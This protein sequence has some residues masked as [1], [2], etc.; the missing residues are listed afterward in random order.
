[1]KRMVIA[2]KNTIGFAVVIGLCSCANTPDKTLEAAQ[3]SYVK[4]NYGVTFATLQ[5][6][7]NGGDARAQYAL[8]YLYYYGIGRQNDPI[9][10]I[11]WFTLAANQGNPAAI[12]AL[13]IIHRQQPTSIDDNM[14]STNNHAPQMGPPMRTIIKPQSKALPKPQCYVNNTVHAS[15]FVHNAKP[16][17][18][19][20]KK[21]QAGNSSSNN[22][23]SSNNNAPG[24]GNLTLRLYA[25]YEQNKAQAFIHDNNLTS[26]AT[27]NTS[28]INGKTLYTVTYGRYQSMMQAENAMRS[29][30]AAVQATKPWVQKAY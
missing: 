20:N 18:P 8:G 28:T 5:S 23:I 26:A 14:R 9:T 7:A 12:Q 2:I 6:S 11:K 16:N 29:L 21:V 4:K 24:Q 22:N 19:S 15:S 27:I 13:N 10:A 25:N 1:M 30:P 3:D 17:N